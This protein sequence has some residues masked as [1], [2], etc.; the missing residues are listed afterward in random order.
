MT[1]D[2]LERL[3]QIARVTRQLDG[4]PSSAMPR[5]GDLVKLGLVKVHDLPAYLTLWVEPTAKGWEAA[6]V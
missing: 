1:P 6:D 3:Q 5:C 2:Q 4:C